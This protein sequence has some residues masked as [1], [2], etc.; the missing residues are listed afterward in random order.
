MESQDCLGKLGITISLPKLVDAGARCSGF[1]LKNKLAPRSGAFLC[2]LRLLCQSVR[3]AADFDLMPGPTA[4]ATPQLQFDQRHVAMPR[5]DQRRQVEF[6]PPVAMRTHGV[7]RMNVGIV[8][9]RWQRNQRLL[10]GDTWRGRTACGAP[11]ASFGLLVVCCCGVA[12]T[13][14]RRLRPGGVHLRRRCTGICS[15]RSGRRILAV[16]GPGTPSGTPSTGTAYRTACTR[17]RPPA[18]APP[19]ASNDE[20]GA[21]ARASAKAKAHLL[22]SITLLSLCRELAR[23]QGF[24]AKGCGLVVSPSTLHADSTNVPATQ[25]AHTCQQGAAVSCG[26]SGQGPTEWQWQGAPKKVKVLPTA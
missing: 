20:T 9:G 15:S 16:G 3:T 2:G 6:L 1:P 17:T 23:R 14:R 22:F 13:G 5:R 7:H 21:A 26:K 19:A 25:L 10:A 24:N 12:C 18:P 8:P 11:P 4:R